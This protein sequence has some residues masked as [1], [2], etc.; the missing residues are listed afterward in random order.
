L[1]IEFISTPNNLPLRQMAGLYIH[2]PFCKQACHYCDFHFSTN[3]SLQEQL[4]NALCQEIELQKYFLEGEPLETIYF[5][6][7]TPSLLTDTQFG[8]I[9]ESIQNNFS[10]KEAA[11]ITVEANPDDLTLEKLQSMRNIG[12]NRLSIGIQ[13]F[14]DGSLRLLNRSHDSFE[15]EKSFDR[16]RNVGF[17]N[18]SVDLIYAIPGRD[19]DSLAFDLNKLR[20]LSPEHVSA[21][22]LT[23]EEQTVFGKWQRTKKFTAKP[24]EENAAEFEFIMDSL[25]ASGFSHYEISNYARPGFVAKHNSNY[26]KGKKYLGIGPSAHSFSGG[27]RQSNVSNNFSYL[28]SISARI[29]PATK[30]TLSKENRINEY[31]MTSLRTSWGCDLDFLLNHYQYDLMQH[32]QAY[33]KE[34]EVGG[35]LTIDRHTIVLTKKGKMLADKITTDLFLIA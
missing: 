23:V 5:G 17:D 16:A 26:W 35:L 10:I 28:K 9:F 22:S 25:T 21:Y 34:C 30:E 7:G 20:H 8:A 27:C 33:I 24:D 12:L 11:E 14:H 29:V 15:A 31:L 6:G 4:V 1:R 32:Q 13:S 2:I 19:M 18:I 3:R